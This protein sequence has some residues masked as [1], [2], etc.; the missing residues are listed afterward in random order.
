MRRTAAQDPV[1]AQLVHEMQSE[2][3][4][5]WKDLFEYVRA[6]AKWDL[7][8]EKVR[9]V[10]Q[11]MAV[12]QRAEKPPDPQVQAVMDARG[13]GG[14]L[15]P[16]NTMRARDVPSLRNLDPGRLLAALQALVPPNFLPILSK[17][18][19]QRTLLDAKIVFL[20]QIFFL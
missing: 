7:A 6:R 9:R 13:A 4:A 10:L 19:L 1:I 15:V 18:P 20:V 3:D 8:D 2:I 17:S 5:R 12:Q 11:R 14:Q 16:L